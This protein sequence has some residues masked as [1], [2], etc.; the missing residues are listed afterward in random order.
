[1]MMMALGSVVACDRLLAQAID[2][3]ST[4]QAFG[5]PVSK[6]QTTRHLLAN[7]ATETEAARALC[8]ATLWRLHKGENVTKEASMCK[9]FACELANRVA[10]RCLQLHGGYGYMM[11]YDV[12]RSWRDLR[13]NTIGGGTTEIMLEIISKLMGL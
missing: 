7:L 6:F 9:V 1:R 8:Y 10:D 5:R 12:Q 4:R 13:L 2:Y 3:T 11:E